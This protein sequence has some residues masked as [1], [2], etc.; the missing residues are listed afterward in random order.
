MLF[1]MVESGM[2][3]EVV[4]DKGKAKVVAAENNS[5]S[6]GGDAM[7]AILV[8]KELWSKGVWCGQ[9]WLLD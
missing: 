4:G 1:G 3:G 2:G 5:S 6:Q 7:W 9:R 8:A